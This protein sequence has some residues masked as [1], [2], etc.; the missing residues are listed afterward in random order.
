[1]GEKPLF[2]TEPL[3]PPLAEFSPYLQEIWDSRQLTNT[4]VMHRRLERAL[5]E[6]LGVDHIV[7]FANGTLAL[8]TALQALGIH[9][10]VITTPYSFVATT[11]ALSWAGCTPVFVDI[12]PESLNLDP[13]KVEA[14]ITP[15]TRA[16]LA[17]HCYGQPCRVR[18]LRELADRHQLRLIFDGAH[19]FGVRDEVGSVLR[20][21][22]LS[23]V[24]FHATKVFNTFEGGALICPDAETQRHIDRL[25][26]F[27]LGDDTT[28]CGAGLNA[29]LNE[30]SAAFGLLQLRHLERALSGRARID[31]HYRAGLSDISGITCLPRLSGIKA[32]FGHF[33]IFV[34]PD[35]PLTRDELLQ[36]L[37][38][39]QVF[40]RRYFHPLISDFPMYRPMPGSEPRN[41]PVAQ[42]AAREVLCLPIYPTLEERDVERVLGVIRG[43]LERGAGVV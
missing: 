34:G 21:R 8:V 41:L 17:V 33:P 39:S 37:Q 30:V 5:C 22:D 28:I 43:G 18:E 6:Y 29:K 4:G 32:N 13:S 31:A 36:R 42:R 14:A 2:V 26:N 38:E 20:H 9:G 40:A 35:Y 19:A 10:E 12:D 7:L 16:I 25:R 23:M 24:S 1:M 27:G 11:H 15:R 3:L